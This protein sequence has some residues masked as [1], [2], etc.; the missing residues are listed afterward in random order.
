MRLLQD[1]FEQRKRQKELLSLNR[2]I[3][4]TIGVG[5]RKKSRGQTRIYDL[6]GPKKLH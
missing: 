4:E 2:T 1:E 3:A 5:G 6:L